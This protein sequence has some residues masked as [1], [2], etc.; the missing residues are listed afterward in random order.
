MYARISRYRGDAGRLRQGFEGVT[1]ELEKLDGFSH[2]Y[3]LTDDEHSRAMS[4]TLWSTREALDASAERAHQMRT[5]ATSPSDATIE[6]VESY[7]VVLT[8]EPATPAG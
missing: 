7:E 2:A 5:Q 1:A 8:A 6:S 4:I 3:F